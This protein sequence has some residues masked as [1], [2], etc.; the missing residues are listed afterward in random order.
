[1][2]DVMAAPKPIRP[3]VERLIPGGLTA[4]LVAARAEGLSF[5]RIARK[6]H[7][8][9]DIDVVTEQVRKWC[10]E[11]DVDGLVAARTEAAS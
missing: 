11:S 4:F 8:E 6:L 1:M 10:I 9:H 2:G 7:T 3:Y 5:E